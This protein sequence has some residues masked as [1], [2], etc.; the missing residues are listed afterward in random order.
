[1]NDINKNN[2]INNDWV[3]LWVNDRVIDDTRGDISTI[4]KDN[5]E[6]IINLPKRYKHLHSWKVRETYENPENSN[7]LMMIATDRIST[8]DIVHDSII[9]WK[10][11]ILTKISNFW[12]KEFKNNYST[13]NIKTQIVEDAIWPEDFPETLK[14]RT[15]IVKKLKALPV[16]AIVRWYLY[17]SA[18]KWYDT[19]VWLLKTWENVWKNLE[20]C[21]KFNS[22][23]FTPST[24]SDDWD[25]NVDFNWMIKELESWLIKN[26]DINVNVKQLAD[27]I[28]NTTIIMY[29]HANNV[30][31][32]KW[33]I[34]WD[35]K[36][37]FWLDNK[38]NLVV[39]DEVLTPDSSRFWAEQWF[40]EWV[41]PKS[42]DKQW[43]RDYIIF[44]WKKYP[45]KNWNKYGTKKFEKYPVKLPENVIKKCQMKYLQMWKLFN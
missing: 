29:N 20:K 6:T 42:S 14:Q 4:L 41:E 2:D 8:H 9:P 15:V 17:W 37:E 32:E 31:V 43:V 35:T 23:L 18:R 11:E 30:A 22:P 10:W 44:Y 33:I 16:E 38:W 19:E 27:E 39:I 36:F 24:K 12:F 45:D 13:S 34:I 25:V 5:K 40:K 7:E 21:S 1:M 26:N 28:K 3:N